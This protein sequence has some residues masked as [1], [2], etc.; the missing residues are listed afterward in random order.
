MLTGDVTAAGFPDA[1][2]ARPQQ[3][4]AEHSRTV[5]DHPP[6]Y[7]IMTSSARVTSFPLPKSLCPMLLL[8]L[9][10]VV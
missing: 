1:N 7:D 4:P 2:F 6:R 9:T 3:R 8:F 10:A 5:G